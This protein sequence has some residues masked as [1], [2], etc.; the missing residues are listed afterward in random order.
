[1][2][3]A[4]LGLVPSGAELLG[5]NLALVRDGGRMCFFNAAGPVFECAEDDK[6]GRRVACALL[7]D[8]GLATANRLAEA[9]GLHRSTVFRCQ[10]TLREQGVS[11]LKPGVSHRSPHKLKGTVLVHA[12]ELLDEGLSYGRVAAEI[13]VA[14]G[15]VQHAVRV[16]RLCRPAEKTKKAKTPKGP[17]KRAAEDQR[18]PEGVA[19]TRGL[20]RLLARTG[21]LDEAPAMFEAAEAVTGAGVLLAVPALAQQGLVTVGERIYGRLSDGFFGL[22]S[23][24]LILSFM[25]L[26]R[27]KSPEQLASR[28]PGELGRLIGLDRAPEVKTLRRKLRELGARGC[29]QAFLASLARYWV[30]SSPETLGTLYVDGHVRPYHGRNGKHTLRKKR[31]PRMRFAMPATTEFWVNDRRADP[32]FV[33]TGKAT[34]GLL[35]TLDCEILPE[36]QAL[37]GSKRPLTIVFDREGWSP[38]RFAR[39]FEAGI[40][41][42]TYRKG[43]Q[44]EWSE[45]EFAWVESEVDGELVRYRLAERGVRLSKEF[46]AREVR[47]L[48]TGGHQTSVIATD[49]DADAIVVAHRTFSRW[50]QENFF[51]YMRREFAIDHLCTYDVVPADLDRLVPNPEKKRKRDELKTLRTELA[52]IERQYGECALENPEQKRPTMRGFKIAH[53]KIGIRIR[54]LRAQCKSLASET[55]AMPQK[56]PTS[57]VPRDVGLVRLEDERKRI[58]DGIKMVAYRA[59]SD[60]VRLLAPLYARHEEEAR[61]FVKAALQIPGDLLP[62]RNASTL[63]V[64][65]HGMANPRSTTA[66]RGLCKAMT[67][68]SCCF[69][70]TRLRLIFDVVS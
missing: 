23:V 16:G 69:P 34:D 59:E 4:R 28:A 37:L 70:G 55:R 52:E 32:L 20:E 2:L 42:L 38:S 8:L 29:A 61:A 22:R 7:C 49:R 62:D 54:E 47:R 60:L 40:H 50:R 53:G 11:A 24:L 26:L 56:V 65:L 33:V 14:K 67:D 18:P 19:A 25:A 5:D 27:I 41:V 44:V 58:A 1:M 12:Q 9:L 36:L 45:D 48:C 51:R 46:W 43:T 21:Q 30:E 68:A 3:Q 64:R 10:K 63:T 15:T 57:A 6:H 17:S 66:L 39:W 31:V 35:T 13:G